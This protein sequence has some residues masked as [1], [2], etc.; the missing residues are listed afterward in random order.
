M[1]LRRASD[2]KALRSLEIRS[3]RF[4]SPLSRYRQSLAATTFE[5][6]RIKTLRLIRKV[7][8][9]RRL[10]IGNEVSARRPWIFRATSVATGFL[11]DTID[12]LPFF[13]SEPGRRR[14]RRY[15]FAGISSNAHGIFDER[16]LKR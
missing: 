1:N 3:S 8:R 16:P 2:N 7:Q 11:T 14:S 13:D 9:R 5:T 15:R 4:S 10:M 12:F 6:M